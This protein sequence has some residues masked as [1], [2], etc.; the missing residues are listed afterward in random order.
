MKDRK[1]DIFDITTGKV[2]KLNEEE[3]EEAL[4]KYAELMAEETQRRLQV[5]VA[6]RELVR[7]ILKES[8]S[9]EEYKELRD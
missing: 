3:Y 1:Y 8:L 4:H 2:E 7:A 5:I 6:E 9:D